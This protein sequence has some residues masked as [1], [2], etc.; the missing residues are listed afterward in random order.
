MKEFNISHQ[1]VEANFTRRRWKTS[2]LYR[3]TWGDAAFVMFFV[4]FS[5]VTESLRLSY[6]CD[7]KAGFFR[8]F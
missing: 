2:L 7:E 8:L 6:F 1:M 3:L 5:V 4:T